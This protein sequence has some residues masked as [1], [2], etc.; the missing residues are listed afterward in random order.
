[1]ANIGIDERE[2]L[3]KMV[4]VLSYRPNQMFKWLLQSKS[5][6]T[7]LY[8]ANQVGK[9]AAV[10]MDYV[11]R[12]IGNH[13][14]EKKNIRPRTTVRTIRFASETLPSESTGETRNTQYPEFKKR[15]PYELIKKD[16]TS[17]RP[18]M[19]IRDPQGG[20]D[21]MIEFVS[22]SQESQAMAGVQRNSVWCDEEPTKEFYDEQIP[23]LYV[24][25]G[26][27]V[28]TFTP[29]PGSIGW[30]YDE[31]YQRAKTI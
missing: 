15:L 12:I 16:I 3:S 28:I 2:A 6:L 13:P 27:I 1:M 19:T 17:K 14:I 30:M 4:G 21:I 22:Y 25:D 26:D 29:V 9:N 5:Q 20:D 8:T 7:A 18:A 23:R 11:L 31:I 24:S 10:A